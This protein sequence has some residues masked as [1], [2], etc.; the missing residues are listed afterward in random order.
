MFSRRKVAVS[1]QENVILALG[2][3]LVI[4]CLSSDFL[5]PYVWLSV[6]QLLMTDIYEAFG[7]HLWSLQKSYSYVWAF[8]FIYVP[9]W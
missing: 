8:I 6:L 3:F 7:F 1:S 4:Y 2:L 5:V 9:M